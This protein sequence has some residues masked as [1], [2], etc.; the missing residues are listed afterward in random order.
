MLE[1]RGEYGKAADALAES[2]SMYDRLAAAFADAGAEAEVLNL[3]ASLPGARNEFLA[4]TAR[5]EGCPS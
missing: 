4:A 5:A 1:E 2:V 3:L